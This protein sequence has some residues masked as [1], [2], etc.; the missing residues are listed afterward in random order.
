M[1]TTNILIN[2]R[3]YRNASILICALALLAMC[4]SADTTQHTSI[5]HPRP[6]PLPL[7]QFLRVRPYQDPPQSHPD[8]HR[9]HHTS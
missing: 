1:L 7:I 6:L 2:I 9:Q 8:Y 4:S 5:T 3:K